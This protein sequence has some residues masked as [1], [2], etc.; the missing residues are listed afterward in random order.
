MRTVRRFDY[1][2]SSPKFRIMAALGDSPRPGKQPEITLEARAWLVSLAC[3]KAKDVSY[4]HAPRRSCAA[5]TFTPGR[6]AMIIEPQRDS[7]HLV[8]RLARQPGGAA[9]SVASR[10]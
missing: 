6:G 10:P 5:R 7:D 8:P 9:R 3:Q 4:P 1:S 2:A